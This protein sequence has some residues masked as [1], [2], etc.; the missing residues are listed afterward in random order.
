[1]KYPYALMC[2]DVY[3]VFNEIESGMTDTDLIL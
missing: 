3:Y 2:I 1:M